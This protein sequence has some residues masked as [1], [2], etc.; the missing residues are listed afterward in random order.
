MITNAG[1]SAL[2]LQLFSLS[3]SLVF[4]SMSLAVISVLGQVCSLGRHNGDGDAAYGPAATG[5]VGLILN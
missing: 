3:M 1:A 2:G 5:P 4:V